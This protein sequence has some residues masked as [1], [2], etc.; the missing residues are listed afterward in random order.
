VLRDRRGKISAG[1]AFSGHPYRYG[2]S[3]ALHVWYRR[4]ALCRTAAYYA[5]AWR[6]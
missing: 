5:L 1:A 6:V 3:E 4:P 2:S